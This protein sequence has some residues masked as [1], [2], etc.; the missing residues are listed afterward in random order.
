MKKNLDL[1]DL[2]GKIE[3]APGYEYTYKEM[4]DR[5]K[6]KSYTIRIEATFEAAHNLREYH[7]APEPLHG[8]SWKVEVLGKRKGLDHEGMAMDFIELKDA[9]DPL[10]KPFK[11]AYINEV[12]PFD[13]VNPSAENIA[14]WIFDQLKGKFKDHPCQIEKVTVWEGPDYSASV[15]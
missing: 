7:G 13:K 5:T 9:L 12:S 1:R 15:E 14:T 4:R 10:I 2:V 8:H 6:K 11:H 3:F